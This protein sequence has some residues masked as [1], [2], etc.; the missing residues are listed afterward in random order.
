MTLALVSRGTVINIYLNL[1]SV[2]LRRARILPAGAPR[3]N[4]NLP[5]RTRRTDH[6][7]Q[8]SFRGLQRGPATGAGPPDH[9]PAPA[10][11]PE[12][13]CRLRITAPSRAQDRDAPIPTAPASD[14]GPRA[15]SG[16]RPAP[17]ATRCPPA[18][19]VV[20]VPP[21][22]PAPPADPARQPCRSTHHRSR[23]GAVA[24]RAP[25][26]TGFHP[27]RA[28]GCGHRC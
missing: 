17:Y 10:P 13:G 8:R 2:T 21:D 3:L 19:A 6:I 12:S 11:C 22:S 7:K 23:G 1:L 20:P 18:E 24:P 9:R 26:N 15:M 4:R 25:R 16:A 14:N 5:V 28:P 27:D